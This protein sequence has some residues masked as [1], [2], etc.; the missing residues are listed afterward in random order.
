MLTALARRRREKMSRCEE[1]HG[2]NRDSHGSSPR[3]TRRGSD[4]AARGAGI[5]QLRQLLSSEEQN[6]IFGSHLWSRIG[7]LAFP[8]AF[9]RC[10][11]PQSPRAKR[12]RAGESA[13]LRRGLVW[14]EHATDARST[15]TSRFHTHTHTRARTPHHPRHPPLPRPNTSHRLTKEQDARDWQHRRGLRHD[16]A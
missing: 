13:V 10:P 9:C 3:C 15:R 8:E 12:W 7:F 5:A 6:L 1:T 16:R 2:R 11:S 4:A 14:L